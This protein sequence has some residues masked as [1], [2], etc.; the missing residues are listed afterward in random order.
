MMRGA[1][2]TYYVYI[3]ASPS[4]VLYIRITN[5]LERRVTEHKEGNSGYFTRRYKVRSLVYF[6]EFVDVREAIE[7][8]SSIKGLLRSKKI[9][10]IEAANPSWRDLSLPEKHRDSSLRSE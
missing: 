7:R 8:E 3:M 10:L 4:Q 5:N 6:E 1:P 9:A 2:R